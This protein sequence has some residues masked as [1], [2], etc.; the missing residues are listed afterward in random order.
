MV[1]QNNTMKILAQFILF[2]CLIGMIF[3]SKIAYS[4]TKDSLEKNTVCSCM[5][6]LPIEIAATSII[7]GFPTYSICRNFFFKDSIPKIS[8]A[9]LVVPSLFLLMISLCPTSEW[10]SKCEASWWH[11]LWIGLLTESFCT[12]IYGAL[13]GLINHPTEAK[14]Y[15]INIPDYIAL[16]LI[17]SVASVFIYNSFLHPSEKKDHSMLLL[18]SFSGKNTASLNFMM[19]F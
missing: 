2:S 16:G 14:S 13:T 10:T 11:T 7:W 18:P 6:S 3:E 12:V 19:Q 17:P 8:P 5:P 1:K 4:Q 9:V 15:K